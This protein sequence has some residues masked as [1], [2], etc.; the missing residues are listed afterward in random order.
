MELRPPTLLEKDASDRDVIGTPGLPDDLID[1]VL[2]GCDGRAWHVS[3][4][5][6]NAERS[7]QGIMPV[8][9]RGSGC[10]RSASL[11]T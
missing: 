2:L 4:Y 7:L 11:S 6:T 1:R 10:Y 9:S 5:D 8:T 3:H